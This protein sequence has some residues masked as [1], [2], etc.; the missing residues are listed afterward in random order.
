MKNLTLC[1]RT[2]QRREY[3]TPLRVRGFSVTTSDGPPPNRSVQTN[4]HLDLE[5]RKGGGV[6]RG[7]GVGG[8]FLALPAFLPSARPLH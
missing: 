1:G 6:G 3:P 7:G 2:Y 8:C 4:R 5:L